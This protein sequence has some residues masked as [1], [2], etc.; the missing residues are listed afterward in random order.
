VFPHVFHPSGVGVLRH[1]LR[2][3]SSYLI[4]CLRDSSIVVLLREAR[5]SSSNCSLDSSIQSEIRLYQRVARRIDV[6]HL[7]VV[8]ITHVIGRLLDPLDQEVHHERS[9]Q[10]VLTSILWATRDADEPHAKQINSMSNSMMNSEWCLT[11]PVGKPQ[12][13]GMMSTAV[14][15]LSV[16]NQSLIDQ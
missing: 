3:S 8:C 11:G 9:V 2:R 14:S 10:T 15:F 13:E 16:W 1:R 6:T 5:C 12:E 4:Y 7:Q